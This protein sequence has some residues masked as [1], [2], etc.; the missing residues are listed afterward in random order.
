MIVNSRHQ[1]IPVHDLRFRLGLETLTMSWWVP[2]IPP[3]IRGVYVPPE[4]R[5]RS[6]GIRLVVP[7]YKIGEPVT[8]TRPG[9]RRRFR[10]VV[11]GGQKV[12][13]L[14][15]SSSDPEPTQLRTVDSGSL[16]S[17]RNTFISDWTGIEYRT[18][19]KFL[20]RSRPTSS[21]VPKVGS[22]W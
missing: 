3:P 10:L 17:P 9:L 2:P 12:R 15:N 18:P 22:S 4:R 8:Q 19:S 11:K 5:K 6:I 1:T 13:S 20:S 16:W 21:S 7:N 14:P